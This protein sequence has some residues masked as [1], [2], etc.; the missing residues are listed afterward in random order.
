MDQMRELSKQQAQDEA[1]AAE[2][3]AMADSHAV[4]KVYLLWLDGY[5]CVIVV[6]VH[7]WL[8]RC[9]V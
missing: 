3:R 1:R 5:A 6:C 7:V 2:A 4:A 8:W 9:L